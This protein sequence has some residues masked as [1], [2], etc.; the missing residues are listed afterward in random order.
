MLQVS[1]HVI[2]T[3]FNAFDVVVIVVVVVVVVVVFSPAMILCG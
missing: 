3:H 2:Y 1:L